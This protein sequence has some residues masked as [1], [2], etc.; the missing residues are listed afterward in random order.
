M[1]WRRSQRRQTRLHKTGRVRKNPVCIFNTLLGTLTRD[2]G[3]V[4]VTYKGWPLYHLSGDTTPG[5]TNG[6]G[7]E[8][9]WFL[10]VG[11]GD[12]HGFHFMFI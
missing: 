5:D 7:M 2:D 11:Y 9:V 1:K 6:Q 12:Y 8:G 4:Q 10:A 3:T